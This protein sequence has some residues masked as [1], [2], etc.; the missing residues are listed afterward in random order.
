MKQ[1]INNIYREKFAQKRGY[2]EGIRFTAK[3]YSAVILLVL[4]DKFDFTTE[5]LQEA[6]KHIG[7]TFDS[8]CEGYLSLEDIEK[9]LDEENNLEIRFGTNPVIEKRAEL[10]KLIEDLIPLKESEHVDE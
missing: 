9:T 1:S 8:V 2:S 10:N 5:Q 3:S 6:A 7:N 4:K